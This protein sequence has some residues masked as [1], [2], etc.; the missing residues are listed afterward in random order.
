MEVIGLGHPVIRGRQSY[1]V[2]AR[3]TLQGKHPQKDAVVQ[4]RKPLAQAS[5]LFVIVYTSKCRNNRQA[6]ATAIIIII[7]TAVISIAPYFTDKGEFTALYK[8]NI[9]VYIKTS[10]V[11]YYIAIIFYSS[12]THTHTHTHIKTSKVIN[13]IAII[14]Y[15]S[16]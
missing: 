1:H 10:K 15:S 6:W 9:N 14:V 13:Y 11:I 16:S 3:V 7:I 12:H 5:S 4:F 2:S 8:I